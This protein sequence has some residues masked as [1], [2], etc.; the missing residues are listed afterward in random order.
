M[1]TFPV[2]GEAFPGAEMQPRRFACDK[3]TRS[4]HA[5]NEHGRESYRMSGQG[6]LS[7]HFRAFTEWISP[8]GSLREM[9]RF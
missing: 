5:M 3:S 8:T 9:S 4:V 1:A 6:P 2:L 7:M